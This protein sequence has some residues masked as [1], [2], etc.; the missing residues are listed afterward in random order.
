VG[1]LLGHLNLTAI[2]PV[3][4]AV[5]LVLLRLDERISGRRFVVLMAVVFLL[6]L[7]LATEVLLTGLGFGALALLLGL[8]FSDHERRR[9]IVGILAPTAAAGVIALVIASGYVYWALKGLGDA[10]SHAWSTFTALYPADAVNPIV[11]TA[12]TGIGHWWF[13]GTSAKFTLGEIPEATSYVSVVLVA[14]A[15]SFAILYWRRPSTRVLVGVVVVSYLLSLGTKLHVA[16]HATGVPLP[17]KPLN[18]VAL[19]N[20]VTPVRLFIYALLAI[21]LMVA[22]WLA[23]PSRRSGA[24]WAVAALGVVLLVPNLSAGYWSGRP[25][26]PSFFSS[27]TYKRYLRNGETV[28][29]LPYGRYGNSM[30]WQAEAGMSF[31]MPEGYISPEDP[32]EFRHDPFLPT[33]LSG[34]V[35]KGSVRGLRKFMASRGV[36]A[37]V[38]QRSKAGG[39]PFV[40]AGLHLHFVRVGGVFFYRLPSDLARD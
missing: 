38:I 19:L 25:D 16:G 2:F 29:V 24:K 13:K 17:W 31:R 1:H 7:L 30:L 20:H 27:D 32:P 3:P 12:L 18:R 6:Q 14:L 9:R 33:L 5:H 37:V 34:Q 23:E 26:N 10:D 28:L 15:A 39:W 11:P 21:A 40:L 36:S 22:I 35:N 4:A 8:L